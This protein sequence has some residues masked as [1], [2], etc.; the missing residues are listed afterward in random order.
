GSSDLA[1]REGHDL[2]GVHVRLFAPSGDESLHRLTSLDDG[3]DRWRADV[4]LL[5]Q[6]EW[7]FR[8]EA[9][10]DDFRTWQH[11]AAVKLAAG[12]DTALMRELGARLLDRAAAEKSRPAAQRRRLTATAQR[13]R[14]HAVDDDEALQTVQDAAVAAL[15]AERPL[16]SL[17]TVG[18]D[19]ALLVERERAGVGA[20]YE[21]FPRSEGARRRAD[22]TIRS[23]TFR[24]AA[25]R[26]P[27][28]A[29]MGFQVVYLPPIHPIGR[30][31]RKGP[32]NTL[33]ADPAVD[34][35]SPWAIGAAE[36]GHD[37]VHPDLGNLADFRAFVRAAAAEGLEIALDLALQAS[38]DHP[39]VTEH[40]E[41]F[42]TLPDGTIAY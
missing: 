6:G 28:V 2:I 35:G 36:G 1:F 38:P 41:W 21:F 40:P 26:L 30:A 33:G 14:D 16:M 10:A 5:E 37:A 11:A 32:D 15:F 39:W 42:T 31:G 22:G 27:E 29:A 34:P 25:K 24:T 8:F 12:V 20:W 23:G 17:V 4:A 19:R 13:L 9:F 18:A 3:F 7:R